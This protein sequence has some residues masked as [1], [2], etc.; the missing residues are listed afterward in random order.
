MTADRPPF[1]D[2]EGVADDRAPAVTPSE[3]AAEIAAAGSVPFD[4]LRA[5]SAPDDATVA[6]FV[7]LW[8]QLP[9]GRRREV[10]AWLQQLTDEDATLDFHRIHLSA[11]HDD[12][13]ATRILAVRGLW[14]Q[15]RPEY[16]H[17]LLDQ[18][19]SDAEA[20]VRAAVTDVLAQWVVGAEF[21]MLAEDDDD[22]LCSTLREVAEDI[23][24][25]D[26]VRGRSL[27]AVGARSEE[28]V[29]E[30][31]GEAYEMGS[32]RMRLA[33]LRAMGANA[34]DNWL[35]VLLYNFDDDD[36]E[37]RVASA[38]AAGRLLLES[39]IDPLALLLE[40]D[41]E[42]VQVAAIHALGEI[43]GDDAERIL[44]AILG[45]PEQHLVDAAQQALA[46]ARALVIAPGDDE[47]DEV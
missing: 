7:A 5:L 37:I 17:L 6:T 11:L 22:L 28:W 47:G 21:G 36:A 2:D 27:E 4:H 42:D 40:D 15:D 38:T 20:T 29:S 45:S 41:D 13:A 23:D 43:A 35:P 24:E 25:E 14:E 16:M 31:I 9:A 32:Q 46:G 30:L 39:A 18:L 8:P 12:D 10:L 33:A 26:E 3:V 34:D 1:E 44:T 19:R